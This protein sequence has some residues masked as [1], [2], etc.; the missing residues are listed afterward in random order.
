MMDARELIKALHGEGKLVDDVE[1]FLLSSYGDCCDL[2]YQRTRYLS[3]ISKFCE[4]F[5]DAKKLSI[6]RAPGRVNLIGE[7]SDYQGFPVLPM[8]IEHDVVAFFAPRKDR[9]VNLVNTCFYYPA[10]SFEISKNIRP[11]AEGNWGNYAKSASQAIFE[12]AARSM[13]GIDACIMG[14]IPSGSGLASSSAL[15]TAVSVALAESNGLSLEKQN[16]SELIRGGRIESGG[17]DHV[18]SLMAE[19][20]KALKIDF[21]PFSIDVVSVQGDHSF[22]VCNSLVSDYKSEEVLNENNRRVVEYKLGFA[23]LKNM[24]KPNT[25][26]LSHLNSLPKPE[27]DSLLSKLP[28]SGFKLKDAA[29]M[30]KQPLHRLRDS[31][32]KLQNGE[33]LEEPEDGF[34]IRQRMKHILSEGKRVEEAADALGI[35]DLVR[36]GK[37]M[38]ESHKSCAADYEISCPELDHLVG[39]CREEGA[40]GARLTGS[41]FGGCVVAL[42]EDKNLADFMSA[43]IARYYHS[44]LSNERDTSPISVM[45]LEDAVFPCKPSAGVEVLL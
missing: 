31:I 39:I 28:E 35:G 37:L 10:R 13:R 32:L 22:V 6:V 25:S 12:V 14:D 9:K 16:I 24:V 21:D 20:G 42:V 19:R 2:R 34:K 45:A 18:T 27:I 41:G 29:Q 33:V 4:A 5:P 17:M 40:L 11:Y 36:F 26:I 38:D 43:V 15:V 8:A 44:Y 23:L 1:R 3:G 30:L 7:H